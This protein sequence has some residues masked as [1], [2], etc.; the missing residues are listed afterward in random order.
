MAAMLSRPQCV[1]RAELAYQG[2]EHE[3]IEFDNCVSS[4]ATITQLRRVML[5]FIKCDIHVSTNKMEIW[6]QCQILFCIPP[7]PK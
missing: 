3:E 5:W 7:E 6:K 2:G 4:I 1:K